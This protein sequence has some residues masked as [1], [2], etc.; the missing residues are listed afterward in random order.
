M[1]AESP[2][3]AEVR[4]ENIIDP[5]FIRS[6]AD[7]GLYKTV[8]KCVLRHAH[9]PVAFRCADT[10]WAGPVAVSQ[11]FLDTLC[12]IYPVVHEMICH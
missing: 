2:K 5:T 8:S 6:S 1:A 11:P 12:A 9:S 4:I 7:R 3:A 10:R